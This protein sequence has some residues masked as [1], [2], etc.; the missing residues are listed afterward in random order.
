MNA[1]RTHRFLSFVILLFLGLF[2]AASIPVSAAP[3]KVISK[4][5]TTEKVVAL[6]FD[7]GAGGRNVPSILR[8]LSAHNVKATFFLT[9]AGGTKYGN[10]IRA[11]ANQGHQ[12]ANHSY[13]H[14]QFTKIS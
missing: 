6:T 14:P 8:T 2:L 1:K 3:S 4:G 13:T 11:I 10:N 9:G 7:D 5:N 12:I